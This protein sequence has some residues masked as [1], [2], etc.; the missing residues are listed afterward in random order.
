M[1]KES[2]TL[3][4]ETY[5]RFVVDVKFAHLDGDKFRPEIED[6]IA[7]LSECPELSHESRTK[8]MFRLSCLWHELVVLVVPVVKFGS[9][10]KLGDR[11]DLS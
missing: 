8:T 1:V 5:L 9:L 4:F 3:Y 10:S 11:F 2:C 6:T 7:F